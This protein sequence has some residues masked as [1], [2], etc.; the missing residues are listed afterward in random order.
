MWPAFFSP[1]N[2]GMQISQNNKGFFAKL[3]LQLNFICW[4]S[5]SGGLCT[6]EAH[7]LK[8]NAKL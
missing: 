7:Y 6:L 2:I 3:L 8:S 1:L 5:Y 4:Y